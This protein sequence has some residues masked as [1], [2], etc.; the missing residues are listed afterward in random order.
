M[1]AIAV[2]GKT[3]MDT[4]PGVPTVAETLPGFEVTSW[5]GLAAPA[6]TPAAAI[7]RLTADVRQVLTQEAVRARL[8]AI[9]S[10]PVGGTAD[11]LRTR[12]ETDIRKWKQLAQTA[13]LDG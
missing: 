9:G 12:V 5:L 11:E 1:R 13:K 3:R 4:L 7:A 8:L 6:K 2:T 10:E